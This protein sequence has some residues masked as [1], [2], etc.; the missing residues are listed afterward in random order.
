MSP[1]PF[2]S[3]PE[4]PPENFNGVAISS[5]SLQLFWNPPAASEQ[6]GIVRGYVLNTT[7]VESGQVRSF[8]VMNTSILL[9]ELHPHYHY[10]CTVA[11]FTVS[12]GP[13]AMTTIR[14]QEDSES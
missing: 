3:A 7:E 13:S 11:A 5:R 4:A 8:T 1:F 6:N 9:S 12:V 2:I 14:T 10:V